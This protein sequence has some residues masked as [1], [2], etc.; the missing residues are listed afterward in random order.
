MHGAEGGETRIYQ[1][2]CG[3][4]AQMPVEAVRQLELQTEY[5]NALVGIEHEYRRRE[6]EVWRSVA[7]V[8]EIAQALDHKCAELDEIRALIAQA[9]HAR[10][11][12]QIEW[13]EHAGAL[14]SHRRDLQR[15]LYATKSAH[16]DAARAGIE[17]L[18]VWRR[19]TARAVY[20]DF[21]ARGLYWGNSL[22]VR[23]RY[24]VARRRAERDRTK[25]GRTAQLHPRVYDG[26]GFW[27]V[28]LQHEA[29]DV[30]APFTM[31]RLFAQDS[32]WGRVLQIDPVDFS[33]W[34]HIPRS[35]RR[36]RA[37]T[38]VRIRVASVGRDPIW[39]ELPVVLHR[40]LPEGGAIKAAQ[41]IRRRVGTRFAYVLSLTVHTDSTEEV[42]LPQG[43]T[44]A[45]ALGCERR[46]DGLRVA[47][48]LGSDGSH[49]ELVLPKRLLERFH[50]LDRLRSIR[51]KEYRAAAQEIEAWRSEPKSHAPLWLTEAGNHQ[52]DAP[53]ALRAIAEH[54]RAHRFSG[55][56][57]A[58]SRL[59]AWRRKDKRMLEWEAN[60]REKCLGFR[61]D[62][63]RTFAHHQASSYIRVA[64]H[65]P[66]LHR[67]RE[68]PMPETRDSPL[69]MSTR[70][71]MQVAALYTLQ[72]FLEQAFNN[73]GRA[74]YVTPRGLEVWRHFA[75]YEQ[76]GGGELQVVRCPTC[77][78]LFDPEMNTCRH[79][80]RWA[81]AND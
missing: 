33:D 54:W 62:L 50:T 41:V 9:R 71:L 21:S 1:Y 49:E 3:L 27:A 44:L 66:V 51:S 17:A 61:S 2:G 79:L 56:E 19:E 32:K 22:L 70:R 4:P 78:Q 57:Q 28:R 6:R 5:W 8:D 52:P 42:S 77:S 59:E 13:R 18:G 48:C 63:Y 38:R 37:R 10:Q 7:A 69:Q 72:I 67:L 36:R 64:V 53:E 25:D 80:V 55:D 46:K 26:T 14:E 16:W 31:H 74:A 65:K 23:D 60:L 24:E 40:P 20:G 11:A 45:L 73:A 39:L 81:V 35:E 58:F 76:H 15:Q 34:E 68:R 12:V 43:P 75:C 47:V 29:S 30:D